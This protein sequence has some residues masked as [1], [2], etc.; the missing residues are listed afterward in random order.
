MRITFLGSGTSHGVPMIGCSCAVCC[1][2]DP[3]DKRLRP[4]ILV[5]EGDRTILVD[6]TPDLRTQALRAHLCRL[7]AV[8]ITHTHADHIFGLDELRRLNHLM[9]AE[10]PVYGDAGALKDIRRIFEYIFV[11]T[12]MGGGKPRIRLIEATERFLVQDL[13]VQAIPVLHGALPILGYRFGNAAYVTDVSCIPPTSLQRLQ[14][15]DVLILDSVHPAPHP[16]HLGLQEALAVVDALQPR[17]TFLTHLSHLYS[18]ATEETIL[19][20]H[21]RFAYDGLILEIAD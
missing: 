10:I 8:L 21:V 1:S 17:R 4:S 13:P 20:A 2:V 16:T 6:T 5:E 14:G 11:P 18:H 9:G 19:P 12:Q 7:D 15:L 3:R